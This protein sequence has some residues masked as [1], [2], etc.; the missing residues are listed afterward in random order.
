MQGYI[1]P[2][3]LQE[4]KLTHV[5]VAHDEQAFKMLALGRVDSVPADRL[6]GLYLIE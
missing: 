5:T 6:N 2:K 1:Q 4:Y 3:G